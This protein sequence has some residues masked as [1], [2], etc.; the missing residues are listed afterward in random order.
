MTHTHTHTHIH[1]L[2]HTKKER[3]K[4]THNADRPTPHPTE[5]KQGHPHLY[6]L[7]C[8]LSLYPSVPSH[9]ILLVGY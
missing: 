7:S 1:T 8:T 5:D 6:T 4:Q 9:P 2:R 3:K